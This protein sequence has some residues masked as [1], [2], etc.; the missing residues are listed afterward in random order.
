M[1]NLTKRQSQVLTFIREFTRV[2]RLPPT[3]REVAD[4]IGCSSVNSA[5]THLRALVKKGVI[6]IRPG[7]SRGI[8]LNDALGM[9]EAQEKCFWS[10]D[11]SDYHWSAPCGLEWTFT[12]GGPAENYVKFCPCCGKCVE[13]ADQGVPQ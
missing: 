6:S 8:V 2:N 1:N 5:T 7:S 10:F 3:Q 12:D 4:A 9:A 13:I 11:Y